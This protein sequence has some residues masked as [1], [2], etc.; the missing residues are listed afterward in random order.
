MKKKDYKICTTCK[1]KFRCANFDGCNAGS[2]D[3]CQCDECFIKVHGEGIISSGCR[4]V[5]S[6]SNKKVRVIYT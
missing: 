5:W 6:N 2:K 4:V 1:V 3:Y